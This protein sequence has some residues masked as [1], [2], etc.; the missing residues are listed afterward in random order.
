MVIFARGYKPQDEFSVDTGDFSALEIRDSGNAGGFHYFYDTRANRLVTDFVL[1]DRP[2][3]ATLMQVTII[4]K[5]GE[6][7]PRIRLW[8][9]D[10]TKTV[11]VVVEHKVSEDEQTKIIKATV[12]AGENTKVHENFW[13]V[14]HYLESFSSGVTLPA[15]NFRVVSNDSAQLAESLN[16]QDKETILQAVKITIG[17][18]L[19]EDDLRLMSNR[20]AQL[21]IFEQ[22]LHD[23]NYFANEQV[24]KQGPEAVWQEFFEA[25]PWIFGYGLKL[26]ACESVD[27]KKLERITTGANIFTG[28]GK[29]IDAILRTK[30]YVSSL[31]FCEIK[32]HQKALLETRAYRE[33]DVFQVSKEVTGGVA[34]VQKTA[35]KALRT[36][37][38]MV[39]DL[40]EDDGTP[41]GIQLSTVRP[42]QALVIG[43]LEELT[44]GGRVNPEKASS[45]EMYR[46]SIQDVEIL[47]FD[48]LYERASFI[49]KDYE[50]A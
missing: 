1:E 5:D 24:G 18:S 50:R 39:K 2:R 25:N 11:K 26:V 48:E 14:I 20:K 37:S 6:Y 34:Q 27:D 43:T 7:N 45:F 35:D 12:D 13:K 38:D 36:I 4:K 9:K 47:T 29:R 30:G 16:G 46:N 23:E 19:T 42:R 49:V 15:N 32:T 28:A 8:K 17:S 31:M 3:V 33:P 10:K 40:Y 41:T 22:L 44:V 21:K